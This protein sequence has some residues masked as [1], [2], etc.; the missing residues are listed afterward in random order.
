MCDSK[1]VFEKRDS[2]LHRQT[3]V[4]R[5]S[6]PNEER[7]DGLRISFGNNETVTLH[8][9]TRFTYTKCM[10]RAKRRKVHTTIQLSMNHNGLSFIAAGIVMSSGIAV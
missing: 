7:T 6:G 8:I 9:A 1:H 2:L 3:A 4:A 10:L 5:S